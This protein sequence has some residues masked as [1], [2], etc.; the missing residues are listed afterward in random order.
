MT[1]QTPAPLRPARPTAGGGFRAERAVF[2]EQ[3]VR[4]AAAFVAETGISDELQD[5]LTKSTG[6]RRTCT[7]EGLLVGLTLA[8]QSAGGPA[9]LTQV[10]DILH[11]GIVFPHE[12]CLFAGQPPVLGQ[13]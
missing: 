13:R 1:H 8:S 4:R 9:L 7:V 2:S 11:W 10:T 3:E 12:G 5:L 6:R